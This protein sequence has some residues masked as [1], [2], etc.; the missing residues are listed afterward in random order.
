MNCY[1]LNRIRCNVFLYL[2]VSSLCSAANA[3]L[4][5][6]SLEDLM[7]ME[8]TSVSK[9]LQSITSAPAAI[10]VLTAEDILSS[11]ATSLPDALRMVPGLQVARI[12]ANKWAISSRGFNSR[13]ANKMLVL[14]DGRSVYTPSFAGVYWE[15]QDRMLEDIERIEVIRG[16]GASL[17][18]SNAVNGVINIITKSSAVTQGSLL[19]V[20]AGN[21]ENSASFRVGSRIN[22]RWNIRFYGNYRNYDESALLSG[23][24][25]NDGWS[26][27]QAG[28]RMDS[29]F[30]ENNQVTI[31]GDV[32]SQTADQT[33]YGEFDPVTFFTLND[34]GIEQF[35]MN[36]LARWINIGDEGGKFTLQAYVDK[37]RRK[38]VLQIEKR[39]TWDVDFQ[40]QF[41][42]LGRHALMIGGGDRYSDHETEFAPVVVY[43][44]E[45]EHFKLSNLFIQDDISFFDGNVHLFLGVKAEKNDYTDVE[46]QPSLRFS[47]QINP[48]HL[49][50]A[51]ASRSVRLPSRIEV[52]GRITEIFPA[53]E[54]SILPIV[55]QVT[56]NPDIESEELRAYEIGMRSIITADTTLDLAVFHNDYDNRILAILSEFP[57]PL[58]ECP[59]GFSCGPFFFPIAILAPLTFT[60]ETKKGSN[61]IVGAELVLH[62]KIEDRLSLKL[63]YSYSNSRFQSTKLE[64]APINPG[65]LWRDAMNQA[66]FQ[67]KY[68]INKKMTVDMAYKYVDELSVSGVQKYNS[69]NLGFHWKIRPGITLSLVGKDISERN[70]REFRPEIFQTEVVA[71]KRSYYGNLSWKF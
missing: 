50:W 27:S 46:Y 31:Q 10:Y 57:Y 53:N 5:E 8:V 42:D 43:T 11:G 39:I 49:V 47:W 64:G 20:K 18:G 63:A 51:T 54:I 36:V 9:S 26:M 12:D 4:L 14:I 29:D 70:H 19:S 33:F 7:Q 59:P 35:G 15:L 62:K 67:V 13:Y 55:L 28:F 71:I 56:G 38:E 40:Y 21:Q 2:L 30:N 66:T 44:Y 65:T 24:D 45:N 60:N 32:Y 16:P 25:A 22:D 1:F 37:T 68:H 52:Q 6:R 3:K 69:V 17:W 48:R 23:G 61:D 58:F 41:A 34:Q